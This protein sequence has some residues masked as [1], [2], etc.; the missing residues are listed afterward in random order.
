MRVR[1]D[2]RRLHRVGLDYLRHAAVE[3]FAS[4]A[5]F[6]VW[7]RAG[8]AR[9]VLLSTGAKWPHAVSYQT[10]D[11]LLVGRESSGV[12][13]LAHAA[14]DLRVR[15]PIGPGREDRTSISTGAGETS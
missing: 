7:R 9:P 15:V 4:W 11:V 8:G 14:A 1:V 12:P 3:R 13:H 10:D 2:E 6:E 5:V